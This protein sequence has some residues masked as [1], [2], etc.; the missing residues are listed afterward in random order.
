MLDGD[1][2]NQLQ[3]GDRLADARTAEEAYLAAS[4]H[5]A[6]E[7]DDFHSRLEQFD[8][9]FLILECR[10]IPVDGQTL[11]GVDRAFFVDGVA[12]DVHDAA[13]G[14]LAHRDGDRLTR[15]RDREAAREAL[16]RPHGD[17]AHDAIAE[18]LLHLER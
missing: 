3:H 14:F 10:R 11:A 5:G 7:V 4:R 12:E 9:A 6:H 16:G 2:A 17:G 15:V 1:I 18:L 13:K 8:V